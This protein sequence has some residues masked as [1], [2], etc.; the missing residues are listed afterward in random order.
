MSLPPLGFPRVENRA[1]DFSYR[2]ESAQ[3]GIN[4]DPTSKLGLIGVDVR[5]VADGAVTSYYVNDLTQSQTQGGI[6][7]TYNLDASLRQRN[8]SRRAAPKRAPRST[9]T[10]VARIR[11]SGSTKA[12]RNGAE[13]SRRSAEASERS[14]QAVAR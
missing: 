10:Q 7:N 8:G 11:L 4:A 3:L 1:G 2:D 12:H 9:T 5:I 6:T 13:A 14:R